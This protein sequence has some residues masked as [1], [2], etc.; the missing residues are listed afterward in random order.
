MIDCLT[1]KEVNNPCATVKCP[2]M[3]LDSLCDV[4]SQKR[5]RCRSFQ[6]FSATRQTRDNPA[7]GYFCDLLRVPRRCHDGC[8]GGLAQASIRMLLHRIEIDGIPGSQFELL[9]A[10]GYLELA[11][12]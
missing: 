9:N 6:A 4:A 10:D 5:H 11:L 7:A 12:N 8:A 2:G 1:R 3:R